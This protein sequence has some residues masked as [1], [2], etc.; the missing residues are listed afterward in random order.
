MKGFYAEQVNKLL[1]D[2]YF[3]LENNSVGRESH[4][5]VLA[6]GLQQLYGFAFCSGDNETINSL[7]PTINAVF[8][9]EIP[10]P[11]YHEATVS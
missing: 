10:K 1:Q 3:N 2:Y 11:V 7:R 5:G 8:N 9:G 6:S 4:Y